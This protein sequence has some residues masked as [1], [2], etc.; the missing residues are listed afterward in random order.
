MKKETKDE[1]TQKTIQNIR[2]TF[3]IK[4]KYKSD[5]ELFKTLKKEGLP[6]LVK[7]LKIIN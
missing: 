6:S 1:Y 7:L 2:K 3:G 4:L 5:K